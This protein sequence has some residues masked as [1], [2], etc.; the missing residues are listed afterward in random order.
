[1]SLIAVYVSGVVTFVVGLYHV[2]LYKIRNWEENLKKYNGLNLIYANQCPLFIKS[3]DETLLFN[4]L[5]KPNDE[6]EFWVYNPSEYYA[7]IIFPAVV[8]AKA[9][10]SGK[11]ISANLSMPIIDKKI[12]CFPREEK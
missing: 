2:R 9:L 4:Q 7:E 6:I 5:F 8:T 10:D 3:V 1:M 11:M 12:T